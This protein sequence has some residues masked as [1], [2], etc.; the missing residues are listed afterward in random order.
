LGQLVF[1]TSN[2]NCT[3]NPAGVVGCNSNANDFKA[4]LDP[5]IKDIMKPLHNNSGYYYFTPSVFPTISRRC[6]GQSKNPEYMILIQT[7]KDK[8][9][10]GYLY[11]GYLNPNFRCLSSPE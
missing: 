9:F 8:S 6:E 7:K 10:L 2:A 11:S 3:S 4:K 1:N 5:Y